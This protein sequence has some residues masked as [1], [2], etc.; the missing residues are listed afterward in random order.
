M[1]EVLDE[2]ALQR[3]QDDPAAFIT[4]VLSDGETGRRFELLPCEKNFLRYAY[5][6]ND[7]GR[8]VYPE[9]AYCCPKKSGKTTF[10][11]MHILLTTLVFGGRFAEGYCLAN[12]LEQA[13]GRVF[14]AIRRIVEASP[15]LVREA[16]LKQNKIEFPATGATITAIGSDYSGAAGA[17]PSVSC[18]DELWAYTSERTHRLWDEMVPSPARK[19]SC[20]LTVSYAGFAGESQLLEG[21]Y[22]RGLA[23][24][25]VGPDLH[26]GNG[27]LMFWTNEPQAPWQTDEWLDEMRRSL[28]P[29]QY[30]RMIEN[31]FVASEETF[32]DMAWWDACTTGRPVMADA[33]MPVWAAVDASVKHDC[34]ALLACTWDKE[35][36]RVR[37]VWHRIFQPS[38]DHPLDFEG[39]VEQSLLELKQRFVVRAVLYDPYQMASVAQRLA[40]RGL[41]MEEFPQ[42]VPNLTAASQNLYELIKSQG[43]S[44]YP[45]DEIR[46]AVQRAV[47]LE[48]TRGWRIAKEKASHKIDV[49]VALAMAAYAAVQK[50]ESGFMRMGTYCPTALYGDGRI[51]WKDEL[52]QRL[53]VVRV[54]EKEALK[55][56]AEGNGDA[57]DWRHLLNQTTAWTALGSD[58]PGRQSRRSGQAAMAGARRARRSSAARPHRR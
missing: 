18:F 51:H 54:S 44:V 34:T 7:Q 55:Q 2:S 33:S 10:A 58:R 26:A 52:R 16:Y 40:K 25:E 39:T 17:N 38:P 22:K 29:H 45:D 46:L 32:I 15:L 37:Q 23:Q 8:L 48:T 53:R 56:K 30:L 49:V 47:A 3:W 11:A 41:R 50:G 21:L 27:V 12:D 1:A 57:S 28:R 14:A 35:T 24:P 9:Q 19:I 5:Q 4:E 13:S 31:R 36:K 6:L 43:L 20:R 42:T